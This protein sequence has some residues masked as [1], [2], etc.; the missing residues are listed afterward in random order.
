MPTLAAISEKKFLGEPNGT[1][2]G[3][4]VLV[5]GRERP[6]RAKPKSRGFEK[7]RNKKGRHSSTLRQGLNPRTDC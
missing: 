7:N 2:S 3:L 1:D 4:A 5:G 6:S